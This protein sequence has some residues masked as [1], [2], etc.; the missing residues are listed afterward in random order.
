MKGAS[1]LPFADIGALRVGMFVHL[2]IGWMAHPFPLSSFRLASAEQIETL[3]GLGLA[4]V[5]WCPDRSERLLRRPLRRWLRSLPSPR[6]G[7]S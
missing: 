2:E 6:A 3:C 4:R 1:T 5:R 7:A